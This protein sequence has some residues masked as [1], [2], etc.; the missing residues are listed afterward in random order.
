MASSAQNHPDTQASAKRLITQLNEAR[1]KSIP[2]H[3]KVG[4]RVE[5]SSRGVGTVTKH[6]F[7]SLK[8][9]ITFDNGETHGY[10]AQL[11]HKIK[12]SDTT[13]TILPV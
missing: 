1:G 4:Q 7:N 11:W 2:E 10:K 12:K 5:H 13:A 8:V 3:L 6:Q 9:Y